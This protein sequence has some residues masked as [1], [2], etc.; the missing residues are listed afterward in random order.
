[1][2]AQIAYPVY[3]WACVVF[4]CKVN[5]PQ[6]EISKAFSKKLELSGAVRHIGWFLADKN[7]LACISV[8]N[9]MMFVTAVTAT[10]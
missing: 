1:M 8:K 3:S 10:V 5:L 4:C 2:Y 7:I 6:I 9:N